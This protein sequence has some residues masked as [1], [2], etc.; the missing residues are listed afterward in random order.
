M[1]IYK[2]TLRRRSEIYLSKGVLLQVGS[3]LTVLHRVHAMTKLTENNLESMTQQTFSVRHLRVWCRKIV[4]YRLDC[5]SETLFCRTRCHM[6]FITEAELNRV[7][8]KLGL[9]KEQ[10]DWHELSKRYAVLSQPQIHSD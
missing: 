3:G 9:E 5:D 8:R 2:K 1:R 10:R 6:Q 7:C 4:K